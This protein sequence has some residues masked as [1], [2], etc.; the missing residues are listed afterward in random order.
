MTSMSTGDVLV[1]KRLCLTILTPPPHR[2]FRRL[3]SVSKHP[4]AKAVSIDKLVK[5]YGAT[6]FCEALARYITQLNHANDSIPL[7]SQTLDVL[8]Q[9]VH[10]PF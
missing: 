5:D 9:D 2:T 7:H 3:Q 8:A 4:T 1:L 10:F 6:Y